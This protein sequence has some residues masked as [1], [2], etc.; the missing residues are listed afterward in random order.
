MV[1]G[2]RG[3]VGYRITTH[4]V[5]NGQCLGRTGLTYS[6]KDPPG[7]VMWV[8]PYFDPATKEIRLQGR[9]GSDIATLRAKSLNH[10]AGFDDLRSVLRLAQLEGLLDKVPGK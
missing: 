6:T 5:W 2:P 7:T 10:C 1:A 4:S 3:C 9:D 8:R